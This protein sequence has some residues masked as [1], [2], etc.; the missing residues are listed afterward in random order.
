MTLGF[1]VLVYIKF[2]L[3]MVKSL[4]VS[5]VFVSW[6]LMLFYRMGVDFEKKLSF[7]AS[8]KLDSP[9]VALGLYCWIFSG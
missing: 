6:E 1:E 4:M 3:S 7:I 8:G 5:M 9:R 2:C